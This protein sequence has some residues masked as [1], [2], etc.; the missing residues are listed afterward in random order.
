L[1]FGETSGGIYGRQ[2]E[3]PGIIFKIIKGCPDLIGAAF[4]FSRKKYQINFI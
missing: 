1:L 2:K 3:I 4:T